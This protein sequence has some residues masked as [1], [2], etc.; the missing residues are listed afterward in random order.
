MEWSEIFAK[1]EVIWFIIGLALILLEFSLPGLI[2]I[3]FG[4]G[5]WITSLSCLMFDI[6]F[7][8]QIL[9][10]AIS[11]VLLLVL[12]RRHIKERFFGANENI[13]DTL[14]EEFI[15]RMATTLTDLKKNQPGKVDF[16]GTEWKAVADV[17]IKKG[18]QV[19]IVSKESITLKVAP[20]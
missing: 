15:G 19:R 13:D 11:S 10:F 14:M 8:F 9:I 20:L 16:K 18:Q 12:L 17:D 5:A 6:G 2:V 3:F 1:A 7:N 4:A